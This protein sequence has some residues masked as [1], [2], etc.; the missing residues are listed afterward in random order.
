MNRLKELRTKR[1]LTLRQVADAVE[2]DYSTLGHIERGRRNFS[3]ESL[4][5]TC[6]FF[7]V[8]T[9]YMLGLTDENKKQTTGKTVKKEHKAM[10]EFYTYETAE[11]VTLGHPDRASDFIADCLLDAYRRKDPNAHVAAEVMLSHEVCTI[12]GEVTGKDSDKVNAQAIA[13]VTLER[14]YGKTPDSFDVDLFPQSPDIEAAVDS[15]EDQGAG[16][17]GIVYGYATNATFC[18]LPIAAMLARRITDRIDRYGDIGNLGPDGKAQVTIAKNPDGTF[19]HIKTVVVSVQHTE[20]ATHEQVEAKV[21]ALITPAF[22]D[23]DLTKTEILINPSGRFVLGGYEAD[24]GLTGRKLMADTYGGLAHHGGGAMSGKDPSKVDRS[25]ALMARWV[26]VQ[27]VEAGLAEEAEVS[28]A[29]AIGKAEPVAV[30]VR[31]NGTWN[32]APDRYIAEAVRRA[33]DFRPKAIENA[34]D[35]QTVVWA[36]TA[37][38]GAFYNDKFKW[39]KP[40]E[41]KIAELNKQLKEVLHD[42]EDDTSN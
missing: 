2:T 18:R 20:E 24:T 12:A 27:I 22:E 3:V 16:D 39:N 41:A 23:Y 37:R 4:L 29:Y 26:A 30:D 31:T 5:K 15:G 21:C 17:Q 36:D 34:L 9:D 40:D 11:S 13:E 6:E 38:L 7:G 42:A 25:G 14:I 28:I 10:K 8:T 19:D 1:G 35:L 32:T 33:F